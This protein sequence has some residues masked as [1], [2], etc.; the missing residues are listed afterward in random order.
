M[1]S[2]KSDV[3]VH[4]RLP[5][6]VSDVLIEKERVKRDGSVTAPSVRPWCSLIRVRDVRLCTGTA[7]RRLKTP[8]SV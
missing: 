4:I 7:Q 3:R 1:V 5:F 6:F 2:T 8:P